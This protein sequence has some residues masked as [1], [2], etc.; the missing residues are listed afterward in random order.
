MKKLILIGTGGHSRSVIDAVEERGEY[1]IIGLLDD[2]KEVG[3]VVNGYPVIGNTS[4]PVAGF[5]L[6]VYYFVAIGDNHWRWE[7]NKKFQPV[8]ERLATIIH[9]TAYV[10]KKA[11]IFSGTFIGAHANVNSGSIVQGLCII[12]TLASLDHD[13]VLNSGSS[14]APGVVL[15]GNVTIGANS[16]IATG[17]VIRNGVSVGTNTI[18]GMSSLVTRNIGKNMV[19]YGQPAVFKHDRL[20]STPYL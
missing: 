2:F 20:P 1:Q 13:C 12:N 4:A 15:G 11:Q 14:L 8:M 10:S 19:A 16:H 18:I 3:E 9:P 7:I 17:T 6:G 5:G